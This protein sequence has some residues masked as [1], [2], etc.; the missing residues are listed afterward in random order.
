[1]QQQGSHHFSHTLRFMSQPQCAC[2]YLPTCLLVLLRRLAFVVD[3]SKGC[4]A[5]Q[6]EPRR[7][8]AGERRPLIGWEGEW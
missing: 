6:R 2:V 5:S 4:A 1:M 3:S 8:S 7:T